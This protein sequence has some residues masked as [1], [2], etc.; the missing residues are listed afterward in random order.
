VGPHTD[1]YDVF[2]LQAKGRRRWQLSEHFDPTLV[3]DADLKILRNFVPEQE[4]IAEPGD[5]LYLPPNVAHFGLALDDA[6]TFSIG[7]RAPDQ[8]E[9]M[10]AFSDELGAR[11]SSALRFSDPGREL[12]AHP[13]VLGEADLA[14]F[15]GLLRSALSV[16]DA[17]LDAF[18]GRY[19]TRSKPHLEAV[20]QPSSASLLEKKLARGGKLVRRLGS[21]WARVLRGESLWLFADGEQYEVER[22]H[23]GLIEAIVAGRALDRTLLDSHSTALRWLVTL[24]ERGALEWQEKTIDD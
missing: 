16:T 6:M 9:L 11:A 19:L 18:V 20:G 24:L 7:F 14:R 15:R 5:L 23:E 17:E 3:P 10:L 22:E 8:R 2:L 13:S 21:R 4:F 12:S 1:Q